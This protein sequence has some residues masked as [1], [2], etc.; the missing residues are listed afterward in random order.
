M[1]KKGKDKDHKEKVA[2]RKLRANRNYNPM[3]PAPV[4]LGGPVIPGGMAGMPSGQLF[5]D[6]LGLTAHPQLDGT[7]IVGPAGAGQ[8]ELERIRDSKTRSEV[9]CK[10]TASVSRILM[11]GGPEP[12]GGSFTGH[13]SLKI[14]GGIYGGGNSAG[15]AVSSA[16]YRGIPPLVGLEEQLRTDLDFVEHVIT[17]GIG[18]TFTG[19][20]KFGSAQTN[21]ELKERLRALEQMRVVLDPDSPK[22]MGRHP[23]VLRA[24]SAG[25]DP[26]T[27]RRSLPIQKNPAELV[28]AYGAIRDMVGCVGVQAGVY[29]Q[30]VS[31]FG[32][33]SG[34][35]SGPNYTRGA[36]GPASPGDKGPHKKDL[37]TLEA[38]LV[39]VL[40]EGGL[41]EFRYPVRPCLPAC[42]P[43]CPLTLPLSPRGPFL[44]PA[45]CC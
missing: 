25:T 21:E 40:E 31:T 14:P 17:G 37:P 23:K 42:L 8:E 32:C 4:S 11:G 10:S 27:N 33:P 44:A 28:A 7:V 15:S 24:N 38:E 16:V 5:G 29:E 22:W 45:P 19:L 26:R 35:D 34:A 3:L 1:G 2:E 12:P 41:G 43:A 36:A 20:P 9:G 18:K 39:A 13:V 6:G 30:Y